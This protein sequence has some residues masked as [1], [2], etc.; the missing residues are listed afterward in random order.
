MRTERV[1]LPCPITSEALV[2]E[3]RISLPSNRPTLEEALENNAHTEPDQHL[4]YGL[5]IP[6]IE[7]L[8]NHD[9]N[10]NRG[11]KREQRAQWPAQDRNKCKDSQDARHLRK[12]KRPQQLVPSRLPPEEV[13]SD[14]VTNAGPDTPNDERTHGGSQR[15]HQSITRCPDPP[16]DRD[17]RHHDRR[18][19]RRTLLMLDFLELIDAKKRHP[20]HPLGKRVRLGRST[21]RISH[22]HHSAR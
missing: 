5:H 20:N 18:L 12:T 16:L 14:R 1:G 3:T 11:P 19:T 17:D 6:D 4:E 13:D 8:K 9:E 10:R 7:R 22:S 2:L 15:N 21:R